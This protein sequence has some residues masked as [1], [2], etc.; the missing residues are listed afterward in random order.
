MRERG[1]YDFIILDLN[2]CLTWL[3]MLIV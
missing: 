1:K 2:F 3:G